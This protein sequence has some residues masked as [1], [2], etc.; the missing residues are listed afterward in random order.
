MRDAAVIHGHRHTTNRVSTIPI[1][2]K[3]GADKGLTGRG[4]RIAFLDSG[5]YPHPDIAGRIVE[6]FDVTGEEP[7][8]RPERSEGYQWH[9]TQT[10]VVCAGDGKLSEGTYR[11]LAL[12]SEL[13]LVKVSRAGSISDAE[14]ERGLEWILENHT[15]LGI[16]VL[17]ISLGGDCDLVLKESRVNQLA[18]Q[19]VRAGVAV[20]VAAGNSSERRSIP[21]ASAPSVITV[22]GYSDENQKDRDQFG[23]YHSSFGSTADGHIKPEVIA[24]AMFVAAPILP[25]TEEYRVAERLT[26]ML[27]QPDYAFRESFIKHWD[28]AGLPEYLLSTDVATARIA[29]EREMEKRKIV[30]THYQ[31]VDGTSFAAPITAS[32]IAQMLEANP[33]L[34]PAVIKDIL[35]ST[36]TRLGGQPAIRQGFGIINAAAAVRR[37]RREQHA[38][39]HGTLCPPRIAGSRV[40]FGFH[41]DLAR[42][43]SLAGDMNGWDREATRFDRTNNG[44]WQASIPVPTA[45]RYRYKFLVDGVRWV[46]DSTH[47]RKE[48]D[49][50]GGFNSILEIA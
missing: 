37:A 40:V 29:V 30:S 17:N 9:G 3:L 43:V 48:D 10:A 41:D 28:A 20:V 39:P 26:E 27:P 32:L 12:E 2:E 6:F 4:V 22:G 24:P 13:V 23:L 5:F 35:V 25:H 47:G 42:E 31:H 49:G 14:I 21:P 46:E 18:E 7:E 44:L 16:R 11:G 1:H 36:A 15:R 8:L 33:K 38:L 50:F 45:G 34:G 19:L